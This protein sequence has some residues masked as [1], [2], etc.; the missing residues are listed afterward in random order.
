MAILNDLAAQGHALKHLPAA[1]METVLAGDRNS[2]AAMRLVVMSCG[3][4]LGDLAPNFLPYGGLTLVGGVA[5]STLPFLR[6]EW[7]A[8]AFGAKGRMSGFMQRFDIGIITDDNTALTGGIAHL[9]QQM[10]P[11]IN[12]HRRAHRP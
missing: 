6:S 5:R 11:R 4:T 8:D 2:A 9:S 10:E 1:A 12:V 7:F 3:A